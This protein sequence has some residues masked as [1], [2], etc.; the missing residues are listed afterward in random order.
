MSNLSQ[1]QTV[2][3]IIKPNTPRRAGQAAKRKHQ[4]N[5]FSANP[6]GISA[7]DRNVNLNNGDN[8]SRA[9][10]RLQKLEVMVT[11][12]MQANESTHG[13]SGQATPPHSDNSLQTLSTSVHSDTVP[14]SLATDA[15]SAATCSLPNGHL[16]IRGVETRYL[17]PTHWAAILEN[18][19]DIQECLAPEPEE[20]EDG[21]FS[22]YRNDPD[23]VLS[24]LQPL[25]MA[26]VCTSLPPRAV[27]DKL[28]SEQFNA[29]FLHIRERSSL[30][31][32][33]QYE[34]FW[35]DPSSTSFLW[36]SMLFS[37]IHLGSRIA[38]PG[39]TDFFQSLK[40]ASGLFFTNAGRALVAGHYQKARPYSVEAMLLYAI[41][42]FFQR[43]ASETEPWLLMGV[44]ARLA[45]RMG[46]HRDPSHLAHISPFEG[47]MRRRVFSTVQTFELLLSF[48]AGLPAIIHE[49]DYDTAPPSNLFDEDF[50]E[51]STTIPPSRP[52]TDPTPMLYYCYKGHLAQAFRKVAQQALSPRFPAYADVLSL[53]DELRKIRARIPPS[54]RWRP[55]GSSITDATHTI[56]HRLNV[57]L[58][59]QK[60]MMILHR[61]YLSHDRTNPKFQ[62]S[63][64]A[65]I[66]ASFQMLQYQAEV[67]RATR[68]GGLLH[69]SQW[70]SANLAH[71]DFL[72]AAM[73]TCLDLYESHR[74][75]GSEA[76]PTLD[77]DAQRMRYDA[78]KVS[79]DIWQSQTST[80]SDA[81]RAS[82][83]L[84]TM[85]SKIPRPGPQKKEEV[86]GIH[87]AT[88]DIIQPLSQEKLDSARTVSANQ[89]GPGHN[90]LPLD[91]PTI[92]LPDDVLGVI[93]DP[94]SRELLDVFFSDSDMID[95]VSSVFPLPWSVVVANQVVAGYSR[96][97][98]PGWV[99]TDEVFRLLKPDIP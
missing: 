4:T 12:L 57:E 6:S 79:H 76:M 28:L 33:E 49:E 66:G 31:L 84:A 48:Q 15:S 83:I 88:A 27:V 65:C 95:W 77:L 8:I 75:T 41:S 16:A 98:H 20:A 85:L 50:D 99:N 93:H 36:I 52:P 51:Y 60:G 1:Y 3:R 63:R 87:S 30:F 47:E 7:P 94:A 32:R 86:T 97:I 73:I 10:S 44:A 70:T 46:Y 71:H 69:N 81:R 2:F 42:R 14:A 53:D 68:P 64:S 82:N 21:D 92:P 67:D 18:I 39:E 23:I 61:K 72:L 19:K 54:L 55:P 56:V 25:S 74:Q 45:L 80:S 58:V 43:G 29:R 38:R 78:L 62:Y 59:Y 40:E 96:S 35:N 91:N 22:T 9:Q 17:G 34:S 90:P 37:L 5:G 13:Q 24:D 26:E 89:S 11:T